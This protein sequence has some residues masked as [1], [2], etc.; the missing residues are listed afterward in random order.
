MATACS[1]DLG[2]VPPGIR[3]NG[4]SELMEQIVIITSW[5]N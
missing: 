1:G 3:S 4:Q 5:M 2:A